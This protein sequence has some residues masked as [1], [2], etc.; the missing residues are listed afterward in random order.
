MEK[1]EAPAVEE[2]FE[3]VLQTPPTTPMEP[4]SPVSLGYRT[5]AVLHFLEDT[6]VS[7]QESGVKLIPFKT[8]DDDDTDNNNNSQ[9]TANHDLHKHHSIETHSDFTESL[10]LGLGL[11]GSSSTASSLCIAPP[12][13]PRSTTPVMTPDRRI[14]SVF[15]SSATD[16]DLRTYLVRQDAHDSLRV[17]SSAKLKEQ[18]AQEALQEIVHATVWSGMTKAVTGCVALKGVS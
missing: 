4:L 15:D 2:D 10:G 1:T 5:Q 17:I 3:I 8:D 11:S 16:E 7:W 12:C 18:A 14:T 13:T 9:Y 6:S